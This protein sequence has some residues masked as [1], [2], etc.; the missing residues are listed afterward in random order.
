V[1]AS[2]ETVIAAS[3]VVVAIDAADQITGKADEL[4]RHTLAVE[5]GGHAQ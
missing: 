1:L 5:D 3:L 4:Y 2:W